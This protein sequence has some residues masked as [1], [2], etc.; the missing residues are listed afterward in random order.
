MHS[1][2]SHGRGPAGKGANAPVER[3]GIARCDHDLLRRNAKLIGYNLGK[4]GLM[5]LPLRCHSSCSKNAT[6]RLDSNMR[7]LVWSNRC[8]LDII[9]DADPQVTLLLPGFGLSGREVVII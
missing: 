8:S 4:D 1:R 5:R 3:L 7:S 6:I 9:A 2:A